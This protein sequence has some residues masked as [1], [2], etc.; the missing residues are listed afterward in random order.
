[1]IIEDQA[2]LDGLSYVCELDLSAPLLELL[3]DCL[4][5]LRVARF[6][7]PVAVTHL[8]DVVPQQVMQLCGLDRAVAK[9]GK[10][11]ARSLG[12]LAR[13]APMRIVKKRL[14]CL[15][16][17]VADV[18]QSRAM[19]LKEARHSLIEPPALC[20]LRWFNGVVLACEIPE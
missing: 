18:T 14:F 11:R 13:W 19:F 3:R 12:P 6:A 9:L 1:V 15:S 17:E 8:L 5:E 4:P 7:S 2:L 16:R 10:L 20:V